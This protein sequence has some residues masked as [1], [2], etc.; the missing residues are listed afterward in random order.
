MAI[1]VT[2][3]DNRR[4]P[5]IFTNYGPCSDISAPGI[6]ILSSF[7]VNDLNM[8]QGTSMAA[9]IVS[10]T[11]ALMK[12][13]KKDLTVEQAANALYYSGAQVYGYIPPMV[14][15]DAALQATRAG[16]FDKPAERGYTPVP[17]GDWPHN[18]GVINDRIPIINDDPEGE[19]EDGRIDGYVDD[20]RVGNGT[21]DDNGNAVPV[22]PR[23]DGDGNRRDPNVKN[24]DT[25]PDSGEDYEAIRRLIR[26]YKRK[27]S[28]LEKQLPENKK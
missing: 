27:I 17:E 7:P 3:V 21:G 13:I 1:T 25:T 10:G 24:P 9:P 16:K 15:V 12:S 23:V 4:Y 20:E 11:I 28:E 6:D 22:N 19:I 5:T 26:D 18:N 2:A 8:L 14:Q